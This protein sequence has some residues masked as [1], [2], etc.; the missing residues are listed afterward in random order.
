MVRGWTR[1]A[2]VLVIRGTPL[3]K[4]VYRLALYH[5]DYS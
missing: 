4:L 5:H 1:L 2:A 3:T